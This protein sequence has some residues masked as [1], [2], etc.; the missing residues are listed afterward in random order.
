M[1]DDLLALLLL[2][3]GLGCIV[4]WGVC[5]V[6][7]ALR[8]NRIRRQADAIKMHLVKGGDMPDGAPLSLA[9]YYLHLRWLGVLGNVL[10]ISGIVV[11]VLAH[12]VLF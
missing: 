8:R 12:T 10:L 5:N 2:M 4:A 11:I 6:L 7:A 9:R 3:S 1:R